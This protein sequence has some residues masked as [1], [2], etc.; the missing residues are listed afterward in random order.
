MT[1]HIQVKRGEMGEGGKNKHRPAKGSVCV[2]GRRCRGNRRINAIGE[3]L[4]PL[5][6]CEKKRLE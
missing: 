5:G 2:L 3:N 4:E 6:V 1:L